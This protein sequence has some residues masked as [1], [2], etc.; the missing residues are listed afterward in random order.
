MA[1]FKKN[2]P[3]SIGKSRGGWN[4]KVHLV[5]ADPRT[6]VTF[7]VSEGQAHD[8]PQG[9]RLLRSLGPASRPIHLIM[10]PRL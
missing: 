2:G 7:C 4:T 5:A 1:P 10:D 8:A 6:A 9:R 3:Q